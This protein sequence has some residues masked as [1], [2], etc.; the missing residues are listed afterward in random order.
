MEIFRP[1][2]HASFCNYTADEAFFFKWR[3]KI[4]FPENAAISDSIYNCISL[5]HDSS[6]LVLLVVALHGGNKRLWDSWP[7]WPRLKSPVISQQGISGEPRLELDINDLAGIFIM[8]HAQFMNLNPRHRCSNLH[9][10]INRYKTT[11]ILILYMA[12]LAQIS[13]RYPFI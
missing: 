11:K 3:P 13:N 1:R 5:V 2:G 10:V 9:S 8:P 4:V 12:R 7:P 6:L